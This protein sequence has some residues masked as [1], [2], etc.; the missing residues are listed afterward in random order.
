[1]ISYNALFEKPSTKNTPDFKEH[2]PEE[3]SSLIS[4]LYSDVTSKERV[5]TER[6]ED[7]QS[8]IIYDSNINIDSIRSIADFI[9][10]PTMNL[11]V[12]AIQFCQ[13]I[14]SFV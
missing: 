6:C 8:R 1:M 4:G 3:R 12:D 10:V 2:S 9:F 11:E 7:E 5:I 13:I 14:Q